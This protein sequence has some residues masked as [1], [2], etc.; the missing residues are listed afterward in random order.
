VLEPLKDLRSQVGSAL[1]R[2]EPDERPAPIDR[3]PVP[4]RFEDL[5]RRY[6]ERLGDDGR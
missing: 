3:D 2:L 5:V 4:R 6:Y 1:R